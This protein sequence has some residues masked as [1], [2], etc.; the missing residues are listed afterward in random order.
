MGVLQC[1][2]WMPRE[3]RQASVV[4]PA[5][6]PVQGPEEPLLAALCLSSPAVTPPRASSQTPRWSH[7]TWR[8]CACGPLKDPAWD[9]HCKAGRGQGR[10]EA[11]ALLRQDSYPLWIPRGCPRP[12]QKTAVSGVPRRQCPCRPLRSVGS[13]RSVW[14]NM[15]E[16]GAATLCL[17]WPGCPRDKPPDISFPCQPHAH[18]S[19]TGLCSVLPWPSVGTGT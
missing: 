8:S 15:A 11:Q 5:G 14:G 4:F 12:R 18:T 16:L 13:Y 9:S 3:A 17:G 7:A 19:W 1:W 10:K 6:S 2:S